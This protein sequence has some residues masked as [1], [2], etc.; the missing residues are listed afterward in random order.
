MMT[1]SDVMLAGFEGIAAVGAVAF[2]AAVG[3]L[4]R[5]MRRLS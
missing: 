5:M 4:G 3:L 1:P 2:L